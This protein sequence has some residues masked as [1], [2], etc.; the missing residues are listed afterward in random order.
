MKTVD[1]HTHTSCSDGTFTPEELVEYAADKNLS[2]VAITDHDILSGIEEAQAAGDRLGI[3]VISG[4]EVSTEYEGSDIHIVGLFIDI[5]NRELNLKLD[6]MREKRTKRNMLVVEKLQDIGLKITFD[7]VK[8]AAQGGIITRA[9][10][11]KAL[12]NK[13]YISSNQ[14]AFDRYIG[15]GKPAYV[16]REVLD[17][18]ET[19]SVINNAGG[20]AVMAHPLLYKFSKARLENIVSD[21]AMH[22]LKGIEAYYSTHSP[23]DVKY[24]KMIADKNKLKISGGSDFHGANK[25]KLDLATGY[26]SLAVPYNVLEG[27]RGV[28]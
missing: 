15:R 6:A 3:E 16:K 9:H 28:V 18:R 12:R 27:L 23:S 11:A 25:P 7:D 20:I 2:A 17:W 13:G 4:V 24:I 26:G 14:E 21:M 5:F 22:G 1:L 10:F 8:N 19:I